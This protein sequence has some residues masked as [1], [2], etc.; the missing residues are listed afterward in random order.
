MRHVGRHRHRPRPARRILSTRARRRPRRWQRAACRT[1]S[2]AC[3]HARPERSARR[4]CATSP[5]PTPCAAATAMPPRL[6]L[7]RMREG[8][9]V[10]RAQRQRR[11]ARQLLA[12][13]RKSSIALV[14]QVV[15]DEGPA[16][17]G[18]LRKNPLPCQ[19][20]SGRYIGGSC[21][22]RAARQLSAAGDLDAENAARV[23]TEVADHPK[24]APGLVLVRQRSRTHSTCQDQPSRAH[25]GARSVE[26]P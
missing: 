6:V 16:N 1:V 24:D 7:N 14:D 22:G 18:G 2:C 10:Q 26:G 12:G 5:S 11:S 13:P 17:A 4:P 21:S 3:A 20:Q 8:R 23:E 25:L 9:A 15:R 19:P